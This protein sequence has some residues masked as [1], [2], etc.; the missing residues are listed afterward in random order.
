MDT[1]GDHRGPAPDTR[2]EDEREAEAVVER[3]IAR[4]SAAYMG[5]LKL[6]LTTLQ[7]ARRGVTPSGPAGGNVVRER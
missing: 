3:F 6:R 4:C 1:N 5:R 2:T 7:A